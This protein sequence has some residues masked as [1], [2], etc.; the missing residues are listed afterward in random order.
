[1]TRPLEGTGIHGGRRSR[2]WLHREPGPL[3]FRVGGTLVAA[4]VAHVVDTERC[5]VLG[6]GGARVAVVEHL[7]AACHALGFWS[8]LLIEVEGDELPILD[9]SAAPW[10]EALAVLGPPPPTP[11]SWPVSRAIRWRSGGNA[12][13]SVID[14][15]PGEAVLEVSIDFEHPAIGRQR[16]LGRRADYPALLP[17]RTFGFAREL[18]A[19]QARG[20]AEGARPGSGILFT[21]EG[22]S[23][24]LRTADEPVRHKALD[25]I[26]DL[27]LLGRPLGGRV[28]IHRGS[29]RAHIDAMRHFL[30]THPPRPQDHAA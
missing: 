13:D 4:D 27:A 11:A 22:P 10:R 14:I 17:A 21:D 5:T 28:R 23:G 30:A 6:A 9:G 8:G 7:L 19:L 1:L 24:P 16:W 12:A 2:V 20:L 25:A 29:H 26:G 18:A 15:L 3:R